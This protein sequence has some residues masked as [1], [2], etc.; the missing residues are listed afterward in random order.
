MFPF[1]IPRL[2]NKTGM[3]CWCCSCDLYVHEKSTTPFG[4]LNTCVQYQ[5]RTNR[6]QHF[7]VQSECLARHGMPF[8]ILLLWPF[9]FYFLFFM[10]M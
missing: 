7:Y 10:S 9:L 5:S 3:M 2:L 6:S 4:Q 1:K 8:N